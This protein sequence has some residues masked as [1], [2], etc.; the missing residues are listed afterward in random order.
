MQFDNRSLSGAIDV[1]A[2]LYAT[3]VTLDACIFERN[4]L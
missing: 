3:N 2:V 4:S 1:R